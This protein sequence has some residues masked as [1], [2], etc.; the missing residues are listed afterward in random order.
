[1][2][3]AFR[4]SSTSPDGDSNAGEFLES[5]TFYRQFKG[6]RNGKVFLGRAASWFF[7]NVAFVSLYA[8]G[9][10]VVRNWIQEYST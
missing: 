4:H 6:W 5:Q 2:L 9:T 8:T 1:M 3:T 7:L 10:P